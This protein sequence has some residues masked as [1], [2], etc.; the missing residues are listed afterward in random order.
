ML[1]D[2]HFQS[3]EVAVAAAVS[4]NKEKQGLERITVK[5]RI[6]T[7]MRSSDLSR[8]DSFTSGR[9]PLDFAASPNAIVM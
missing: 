3:P 2:P 1:I 6:V 8:L 4:R 9:Y 7:Y 5:L